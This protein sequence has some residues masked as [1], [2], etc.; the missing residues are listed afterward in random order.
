LVLSLVL[1]LGY[2]ASAVAD[3]IDGDW[4]HDDGRRFSIKEAVIVTPG[5]ASLQ[6]DYTRHSFQYFSPPSEPLA[7]NRVSMILRGDSMIL[8]GE[9][10]VEV[11]REGMNGT[12][13]WRRCSAATT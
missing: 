7:G 5:G 10:S 4:C 1:V 12:E 13:V 3:A 11:H 6:G 2:S 8:R 9:T